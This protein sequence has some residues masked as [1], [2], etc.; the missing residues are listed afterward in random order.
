MEEG[1]VSVEIASKMLAAI[2]F[3]NEEHTNVVIETVT[4]D[5]QMRYLK[6]YIDT[7][8]VSD[9]YDIGRVLLLNNKGASIVSCREGVVIDMDKIP[10]HVVSQMYNMLKAKIEKIS[11]K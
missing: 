7:V 1:D 6:R 11:S 4:L 2:T 5:E 3:G 9:R 10:P 8:P